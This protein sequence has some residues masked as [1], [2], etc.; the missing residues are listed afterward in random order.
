[1]QKQ[2][3]VPAVYEIHNLHRVVNM[4]TFDVIDFHVEIPQL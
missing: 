4:D 1:M 3:Y 2:I